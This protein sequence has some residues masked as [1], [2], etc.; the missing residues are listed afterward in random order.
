MT[1]VTF[2]LHED[3][4]EKMNRLEE[5]EPTTRAQLRN[6]LERMIIQAPNPEQNGEN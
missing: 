1:E 3:V 4:A 5:H 2:D 6:E